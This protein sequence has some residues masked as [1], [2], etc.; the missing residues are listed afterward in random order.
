MHSVHKTVGKKYRMTYYF[1][2]RFWSSHLIPIR[3]SWMAAKWLHCSNIQH[4]GCIKAWFHSYYIC[5]YYIEHT[6]G[7]VKV[8]RGWG[9]GELAAKYSNT[10]LVLAVAVAACFRNPPPS[11]APPVWLYCGVI[12]CMLY[13]G[14][15]S[16]ICAAAVF[17]TC[18]QQDVCECIGSLGTCSAVAEVA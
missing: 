13:T 4:D 15:I 18:S 2:L 9:G 16:Y 6:Q 8:L 5:S 10:W 17:L 11:P 14:V 1:L 12:S 7:C 3:P